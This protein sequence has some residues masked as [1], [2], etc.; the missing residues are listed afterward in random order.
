MMRR[1]VVRFALALALIFTAATALTRAQPP[2]L[3]EIEITSTQIAPCG[4]PCILGRRLL[5]IPV[6][7]VVDVLHGSEWVD[8]VKVSSMQDTVTWTWSGHQPDFI[9]GQTS[10]FLRADPTYGVIGVYVRT[11]IPLSSLWLRYGLPPIGYIGVSTDSL[12]HIGVYPDDSFS[13]LTEAACPTSVQGF[14]STPIT[15]VWAEPLYR[16]ST[17]KQSYLRTWNHFVAC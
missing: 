5:Y 1:A 14:S 7:Q 2:R 6:S 13:T 4:D 16:D 10:G 17:L 12:L 15:L 8:Q 11:T 3:A 9:D